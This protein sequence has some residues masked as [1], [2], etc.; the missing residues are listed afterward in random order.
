MKQS[1][2]LLSIFLAM[3]MLLGTVSVIG[4]AAKEEFNK[5]TI[6]YDSIDNAA[7]SAEQVADIVL[8]MVDDMLK[9]IDVSDINDIT[10]LLGLK[11]NFSSVD[12][13][14][15]TI[16]GARDIIKNGKLGV[17]LGGDVQNLDVSAFNGK[18]RAKTGDIGMVVALLKFLADNFDGGANI[19]K[20]VLGI[21][22]DSKPN[23]FGV[24][25]LLWKGELKIGISYDLG[26]SVKEIVDDPD[27]LG[28]G[29]SI[30]GIIADLQGFVKSLV[31]DMLMYGSYAYT[32]DGQNQ[33]YSEV[34]DQFKD[35][36]LD[37]MVDIILKNFLTTPQE[38][39]YVPT[40]AFDAEGNPISKKAWD[41]SSYLLSAQKYAKLG[42]LSLANNSLFDFIDKVLQIAYEDFGVPF[43]NND[44]KKNFMRVLGA[45]FVT[46]DDVADAKE[47]AAA[48]AD[49][50]YI[51]VTKASADKVALVKNYFCNAQMW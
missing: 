2:K 13:A 16:Y 44:L 22:Q 21:G 37:G 42:D 14:F 15:S 29:W 3:L 31:F 23:Q 40:G 43:I 27:L 8:D 28:M 39:E 48:K 1:K 30:S 38:Y 12:N 20:V 19:Q 26:F 35:T 34:K 9:D 47:I 46:L 32:K 7:L 17:K 51:D 41:E 50:D 33:Q 5:S 4:S 18:T 10:S 49:S 25:E 36:T 24:G 45:E 11:V 6:N